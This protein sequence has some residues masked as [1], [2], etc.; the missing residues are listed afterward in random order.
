MG[1]Q[2]SNKGIVAIVLGAIILAIGAMG[3]VASI[4]FLILG[5]VFSTVFPAV[6]GLP[7][8]DLDLNRHALVCDGELTGVAP[9]PGLT[10]NGRPTV[11]LEYQYDV[12]GATRQGD[13]F[14]TDLDPL[15]TLSAGSPVDVEYLPEEP[16]VSRILGSKRAIAG[17]AGFMGLGFGAFGLLFTGAQL[18]LLVLGVVVLFVGI[19]RRRVA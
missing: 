9:N 13:I 8:Q 17:W 3:L 15:A 18:L 11:R 6:F 10:V 1:R 4:T 7:F 2:G 12:A 19:R 5:L 14:V 16:D